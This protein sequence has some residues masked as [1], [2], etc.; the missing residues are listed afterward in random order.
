MT[1]S[2]Q[3]TSQTIGGTSYP[4]IGYTV[5]Y[6]ISSRQSPFPLD[7]TDTRATHAHAHDGKDDDVD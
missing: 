4:I 2:H 7:S 3:R 1:L 5:H 6:R